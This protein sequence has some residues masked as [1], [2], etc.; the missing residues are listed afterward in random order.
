MALTN[1]SILVTPGTGATIATHLVGGKE[2]QAVVVADPEGHLLGSGDVFFATSTISSPPATAG[3][4]WMAIMN[5][6]ASGKRALLLRMCLTTQGTINK[7][8]RLVRTT[9]GGAGGTVITPFRRNTAVGPVVTAMVLPT[10]QPT[11]KDATVGLRLELPIETGNMPII[12]DFVAYPPE[13]LQGIGLAIDADDALAP[14]LSSV[15]FVW[16][17]VAA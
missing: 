11:G 14:T 16:Q 6:A 15:T 7:T 3:N 17:E 12:Y 5:P 9:S 8:F 2:H 1:D 10:T 13:L 4:T